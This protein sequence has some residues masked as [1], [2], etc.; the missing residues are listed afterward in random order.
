LETKL[1][2]V[3]LIVFTLSLLAYVVWKFIKGAKVLFY[4]DHVIVV[5]LSRIGAQVARNLSKGGR[6][7]VVITSGAPGPDAGIIREHGGIVLHG[8]GFDEQVFWDAGLA[9]ASTIFIATGDDEA[10]I[11]LAQ[12]ISRLKKRRYGKAPLK[13]MVH[14]ADYDLKNMVSDYLNTEGQGMTDLQPFNMEDITAQL[15]YDRFPPHVYLTDETER[16]NEKVICIV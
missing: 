2:I 7:V 8:A 14:V 4:K 5:G 1:L 12:F 11:K 6:K 16:D 10:N 3:L 13:L 15:V 9:S